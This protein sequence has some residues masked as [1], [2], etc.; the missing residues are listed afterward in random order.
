LRGAVGAVG[1]RFLV[2]I[3]LELDDKAQSPQGREAVSKG[4]VVLINE[5][6]VANES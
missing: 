4:A 2:S 3:V 6:L 1:G 5:F